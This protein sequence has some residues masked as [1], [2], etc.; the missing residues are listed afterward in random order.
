MITLETNK[1]GHDWHKE[2]LITLWK[3]KKHYD[4]L[5]CSKCGIRGETNSISSVLIKST[6]SH[7]KIFNCTNDLT[8]KPNKIRITHCIA[9][10]PVFANLVDG[11][12]HDVIDAPKKHKEDSLGVWV[13]G[14]NGVPVK[15]LNDEF[16]NI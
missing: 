14:V 8:T 13:K 5:V 6:Y 1:Y 11:S 2:N 7:T 16:E 15:V 4:V 9:Y 10:G 3:G 12:E